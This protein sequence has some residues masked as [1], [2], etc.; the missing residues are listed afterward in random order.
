MVLTHG[1]DNWMQTLRFH[2]FFWMTRQPFGKWFKFYQESAQWPRPK[3]EE[4]KLKRLKAILEHSY[5]NVPFYKQR[6]RECNFNP[7][8]FR[9]FEDLY[10]IPPLT[11]AEVKEHHAKMI[12]KG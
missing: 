4:L 11:K 9:H 7:S 5:Q 3:L 6:F 8:N 10:K 1:I 2:S 12:A